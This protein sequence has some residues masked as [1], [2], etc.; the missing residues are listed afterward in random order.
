MYMSAWFFEPQM[1]NKITYFLSLVSAF[2]CQH[3]HSLIL[4]LPI[5]KFVFTFFSLYFPVLLLLLACCQGNHQIIR[6]SICHLQQ[7]LNQSTKLRPSA[8]QDFQANYWVQFFYWLVLLDNVLQ[9]YQI[10]RRKIFL[11]YINYETKIFF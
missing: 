11:D 10:S 8:A 3:L 9:F 1:C 5:S 2:C 6:F 4:H 7:P